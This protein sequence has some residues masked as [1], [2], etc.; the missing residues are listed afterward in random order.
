MITL[1][2]N[3]RTPSNIQMKT[4]KKTCSRRKDLTNHSS[5]RCSTASWLRERICQITTILHQLSR[6]WP[7]E[8]SKCSNLQTR[9]LFNQMKNRRIRQRHQTEMNNQT[10]TSASKRSRRRCWI[11]PLKPKRASQIT[12]WSARSRTISKAAA[13]WSFSKMLLKSSQNINWTQLYSKT[14]WIQL[15]KSQ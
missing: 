15:Q 5:G 7:K 14:H 8:H 9:A 4:C 3:C 13:I 1:I 11:N 2:S 12:S 6:R 10:S